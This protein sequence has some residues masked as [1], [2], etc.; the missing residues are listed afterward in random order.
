MTDF[1]YLPHCKLLEQSDTTVSLCLNIPENLYYF[2]GHFTEIPL[3]PGVVQL[4]WVMHYLKQY[5]SINPTKLASV[6]ALKFKRII[7]PDTETILTLNKLSSTKY[8][9]EFSVNNSSDSSGKAV[10]HDS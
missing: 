5:F 10:F 4:D 8:T 9:F 3:L 6:D 2:Q 7:R 1:V